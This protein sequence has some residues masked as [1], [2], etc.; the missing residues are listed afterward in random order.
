MKLKKKA[1]EE[2]SDEKREEPI[3]GSGFSITNPQEALD[4]KRAEPTSGVGFSIINPQQTGFSVGKKRGRERR[5]KLY[6]V[7][8]RFNAITHTHNKKKIYF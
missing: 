3:S 4:E 6:L 5:Q 2:A 1:E 8:R 7:V